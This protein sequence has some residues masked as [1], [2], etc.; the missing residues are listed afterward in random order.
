MNIGRAMRA[1]TGIWTTG[2]IPQMLQTKM[3]VNSVS[4]NGVQPRP[5]GPI[6]CR[7]ISSSTKSTVDSATFCT[8]VGTSACF[9]AGDEEQREDERHRDPHQQDDLVDREGAAAEECPA[10]R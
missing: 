7:M 3:N 5:S 6:V 8:P 10:T 9:A 1:F 4:R 2:M